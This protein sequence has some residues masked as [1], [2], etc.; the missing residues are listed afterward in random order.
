M[1]HGLWI[2]APKFCTEK[3]TLM[4]T[5]EIKVLQFLNL[6]Y[7]NFLIFSLIS[8]I[9]NPKVSVELIYK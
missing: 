2:I 9:F 7:F 3:P 1:Y 6:I 5:S 8:Y 4:E